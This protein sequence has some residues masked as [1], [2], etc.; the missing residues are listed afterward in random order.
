MY[1]LSAVI[2][3]PRLFKTWSKLWF[4]PQLV[5]TWCLKLPNIP[6]QMF[7]WQSAMSFSMAKAVVIHFLVASLLDW[8]LYV[9]CF[10]DHSLHGDDEVVPW[11]STHPLHP[12][13]WGKHQNSQAPNSFSVL[14]SCSSCMDICSWMLKREENTVLVRCVLTPGY[15]CYESFKVRILVW[16]SYLSDSKIAI[17]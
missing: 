4:I 10:P 13:M 8:C 16:L 5:Y 3:H 9:L 17:T 6:T 1:L 15:A 2:P 7:L 14:F 11:P 12:V